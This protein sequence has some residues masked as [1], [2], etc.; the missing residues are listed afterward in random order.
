MS[1][2]SAAT[3][4]RLLGPEI[5]KNL[6]RGNTAHS[7]KGFSMRHEIASTK[8]NQ[9]LLG[10]NDLKIAMSRHIISNQKPPLKSKNDS[11]PGVRI[12]KGLEERKKKKDS[13]RSSAKYNVSSSGLD[14]DLEAQYR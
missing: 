1:F 11:L 7:M 8:T 6:K 14:A 12:L 4:K 5:V 13:S 9:A 10:G 2:K 3:G